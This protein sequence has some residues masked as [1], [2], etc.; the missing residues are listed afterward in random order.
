MTQRFLHLSDPHYHAIANNDALFI[1]NSYIREHYPEHKIVMPGDITD[2]G[3]KEQYAIAKDNLYPFK[4]RIYLCP[5]NHDYSI[6]GEFYQKEAA[7]RFEEFAKEFGKDGF[8][9]KIPVVYAPENVLIIFLNSNTETES[10][11][12]FACGRIGPTQLELLKNILDDPQYK[13]FVKM[14]FDHHHPWMHS[15]PTMKLL[16]ADD[17]LRIIYG[18]VDLFGFGHRHV[19][20]RWEGKAGMRYALAAG[21]MFQ[22][23]TADEITIEGKEISIKEVPI[24]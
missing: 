20:Q 18:K 9:N 4:D 2:D 23:M 7:E 22:E 3:T 16:D 10:P 13:D 8:I 19:H 12:D 17:L 24:I 5:G 14:L 15:D 6:M 21:A 11:F 1:R